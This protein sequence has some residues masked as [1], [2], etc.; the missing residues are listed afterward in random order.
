[1]QRKKA[2]K[3]QIAS[4]HDVNGADLGKQHIQDIDLM[5]FPIGNGNER[6]D[7][8]SQIQ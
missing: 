2:F 1:M 7:V 3:I 8:A 5:D 4:V 6:R